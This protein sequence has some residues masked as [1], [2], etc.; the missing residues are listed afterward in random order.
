MITEV[1]VYGFKVVNK[2][3]K[4]NLALKYNKQ[5][6]TLLNV[7]IIKYFMRCALTKKILN[8]K[9]QSVCLVTVL[10]GSAATQPTT[11]G[12]QAGGF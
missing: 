5:R 2:K 9:R 11:G 4:N 6:I 7:F 10:R 8:L 12:V 3:D 1:F